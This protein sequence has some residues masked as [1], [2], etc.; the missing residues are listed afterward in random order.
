MKASSLSAV[1]ITLNEEANLG[2]CLQSLEGLAEEVLVLDSGS[3][4]ATL[5][6]AQEWGARLIPV[7]WKG[8]AAT[9]NQGHHLAQNSYILSLDADEALSGPLRQSLQE[10]KSEGL[11]GVYALNRLNYYCGR[12]IRHGG[13]YPDRKIR[14]FPKEQVYWEE[15]RVHE[16][17][18]CPPSLAQHWL[19]GDLLHYSYYQRSEHQKRLRRYARLAAQQYQGRSGLFWKMWLNPAWRFL[20]IYF[21][22]GGFRDGWAGFHLCRLTALEVHL[23]YRWAYQFNQEDRKE[24]EEPGF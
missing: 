4:D 7:S 21:L 20:Q 17:L 9:K 16:T 18:Y 8:Y 23:K 13:F 12:W 5:R 3:D 2:R 6:I 24:G 1:I 10:A 22:R 14:L 15:K 19:E 11:K